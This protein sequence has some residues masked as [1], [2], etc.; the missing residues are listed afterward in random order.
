M[1]EASLV[2]FFIKFLITVIIQ[3]SM[4]SMVESS[5]GVKLVL[6]M[7]WRLLSSCRTELAPVMTDVISGLARSQA[8]DIWAND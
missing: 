6:E 7:A 2:F 1:K 4:L 5:E 8:R 3:R